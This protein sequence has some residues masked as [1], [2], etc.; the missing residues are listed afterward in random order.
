MTACASE[1]IAADSRTARHSTFTIAADGAYA[2][3]LNASAEGGWYPERWTLDGPEPYAVPLPGDRPEEAGSQ[4]LPLS[5]G[6]VLIARREAGRYSLALLYPTGPATGELRL[7]AVESERLALLPPAP[8]GRRAYALTPGE[9]TTGVWLVAGGG[10]GG[11]RL[12]AEVPGRCSGGAWLD[13]E[14][15]LLAVDRTDTTGTG[16]TKTVAV[17]FARH[18][19]VTP[20]L[21]ITD[22]SDDRLLLADIDS[23]LLI[24]RSNAP[25]EA[26]LGWGVLGS[27]RPV[28]FPESLH[29]EDA[30]LTPFAVQPGQML[31]PESCAVALH[32]QTTG[33]RAGGAW[34]GVWRPMQKELRRFRAP[35]GWLP[36]KGVWTRE[37]ELRLPCAT[38]H[39]PCGLARL[40][41]RGRNPADDARPTVAGTGTGTGTG[42]GGTSEPGAEPGAEPST[43]L[44]GRGGA[45]QGGGGERESTSRPGL[46]EEPPADAGTG[47]GTGG[48]AGAEAEAGTGAGAAS[49]AQ[50]VAAPDGAVQPVSPPAS[51]PVP[52]PAVQRYEGGAEPQ[53]DA[54][55]TP[56]QGQPS[57]TGLHAGPP[58]PEE[59]GAES[60]ERAVGPATGPPPPRLPLESA[61]F[62]QGPPVRQETPE[63]AAPNPPGSTGVPCPPAVE[64]APASEG[65][66]PAPG[67]PS[68]QPDRQRRP[69]GHP[70]RP[71]P[72]QDAPLPTSLPLPGESVPTHTA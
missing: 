54:R 53:P 3:R 35:G 48:R 50:P 70:R 27:H 18:G 16:R 47:P 42:P 56:G 62:R 61:P 22:D 1:G 2:A 64:Y 51:T 55:R 41:M 23:G 66:S 49:E 7:G 68:G 60:A 17:D 59:S 8:C 65:R 46:G 19:E 9:R 11:P 63:T 37:G 72:L 39:V 52:P 40:R 33:A 67:A 38:A 20:L 21:Q 58:A 71:V 4:V 5:D 30:L 26:R 28:R 25:G 6:R 13:R 12:L 15:R 34:L 43:A 36:G 14:G 10:E 32:G 44:Q 31:L 24:V 69:L 57:G 29:P 45:L